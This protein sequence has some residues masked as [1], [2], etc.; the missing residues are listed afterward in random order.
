MNQK[1]MNHQSPF[2]L[3]CDADK[4]PDSATYVNGTTTATDRVGLQKMLKAAGF[5]ESFARISNITDRFGVAYDKSDGHSDLSLEYGL[6][7]CQIAKDAGVPI[8]IELTF[9]DYYMDVSFQQAPNFKYYPEIYALQKGKQWQEMT[10]EEM[11]PVIEAYASLVA[12]I[13]LDTGVQVSC[14]DLG[15]EANLGFAGINVGLKTVVSPKLEKLNDVKTFMKPN[16]GASFLKKHCWNYAGKLMAAAQR[17]I[18]KVQ[19]DAKFSAHLATLTA[20]SYS[21]VTFFNTLKENGCQLDYAGLSIFPS[22]PTFHFDPMK[23]YKKL[24]LDISDKCGLP[25]FVAEYAYPAREMRSG[26]YKSWNKMIKGYPH[27][28]EGQ[29]QMLFDF[30]QWCKDHGVVGIHCY[31]GSHSGPDYWGPMGFFE[32]NKDKKQATARPVLDG[33]LNN[34]KD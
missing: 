16:Y 13:I 32:Y 28:G 25:V 5:N 7:M 2:R 15:N 4:F 1:S 3:S 26:A 6:M 20:S 31:G 23:F 8:K 21:V 24:I 30:V 14:W 11:E 10:I 33:R 19:P 12:K 29:A 9:A 27:T 22:V 18:R 34:Q 17:G